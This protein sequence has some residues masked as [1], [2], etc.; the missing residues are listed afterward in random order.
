M[1]TVRD[2]PTFRLGRALAAQQAVVHQAAALAVFVGGCAMWR[3]SPLHEP[4]PLTGVVISVGGLV[5]GVVLMVG[6][7]RHEEATMCTDDVI[8][9]G[10]LTMA[11]DTPVQ[12]AVSHRLISIEKPRSRRRLASDLRWRLK[13]ADG[14]ERPSPGYMRASVLPPLCPSERRTLLG[15]AVAGGCDDQPPR[16]STR[17]P[18]GAGHPLERSSPTHRGSTSTAITW[19]GKNCGVDSTQIGID[20]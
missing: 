17:T 12:R 9:S 11:R 20:R 10:F 19:Q 6:W 18:P 4:E 8:L 15:R 2:D 14:T 5:L 13:L 16:T 1:V 7:S 3:F